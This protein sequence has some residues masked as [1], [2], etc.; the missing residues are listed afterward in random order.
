M[1]ERTGIEKRYRVALAVGLGATLLA[2]LA[3]A[4]EDAALHALAGKPNVRVL[5]LAA[6]TPAPQQEFKRVGGG[7]LQQVLLGPQRRI[8]AHHRPLVDRVHGRVRDLGE[9][10]AEVIEDQAGPVGEHGDAVVEPPP[11]PP[12]PLVRP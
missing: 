3:P 11:P 5:E 9:E 10:L 1:S 7:L 8:E 12:A 2:S 4:F 6:S